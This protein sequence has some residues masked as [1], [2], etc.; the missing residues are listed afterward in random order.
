M[1]TR[2]EYAISLGLAQPGRGRLSRDANAACDKAEA[3]GMVFESSTPVSTRP[4]P[5]V[6]TSG[7]S[8]AQ[9][10]AEEKERKAQ[11]VVQ[12]IPELASKPFT[13]KFEATLPD[14]KRKALSER[15]ACQCG[16]SLVYCRC[17]TPTVGL[18]I[19]DPTADDTE[20]AV[21]VARV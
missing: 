6:V 13:G 17:K 8:A 2:R 21:N 18:L 3:E 11:R 19:V 14:G 9:M 1:T 7:M 12:E 10:A 15:T 4:N 5:K 20:A 16:A